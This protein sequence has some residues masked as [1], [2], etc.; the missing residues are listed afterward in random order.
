MLGTEFQVMFFF[1]ALMLTLC[2]VIHLCSIP[3]APLRDVAKDIPPQQDSQDPLLSSDRMY[4]Y[5]SIEKVKNGYIN[6]EMVL[7]GEKTKNTQQV[8]MQILFSLLGKNILVL[9][10]SSY[11]YLLLSF[12]LSFVF[13]LFAY[14]MCG[15]L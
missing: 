11:Y 3:E 2:V 8:K 6:P 10:L 1:S 12:L 7:Q 14:L 9:T 13:A 4:E 5:G 15:V